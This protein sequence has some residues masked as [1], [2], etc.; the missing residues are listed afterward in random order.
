MRRRGLIVIVALGILGASAALAGTAPAGSRSSRAGGGVIVFN[1]GAP[2]YNICETD[3]NG[4]HRRQLTSEGYYN[5]P[6]ISLNGT[7]MVFLDPKG[8][9]TAADGNAQHSRKL[10]MLTPNGAGAPVI[11]PDG[12]RVVWTQADS[13]G[14]ANY[15]IVETIDWDGQHARTFY[16][17]N[18]QAGFAPHG[19]YIC[20]GNSASQ[21]ANTIGVGPTVTA[22]HCP[23]IIAVAGK[24]LGYGSFDWRPAVSPNG[25]YVAD[26]FFISGPPGIALFDARN[27]RYLRSFEA[28]TGS[29]GDP[30]FTPDG[31]YLLFDDGNNIYRA[32]VRGGKPTLLIR[33]AK[34]PSAGL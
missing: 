16:S 22:G 32:P 34:Q 11:S 17:E 20:T 5:N 12:Q 14:V 28:G 3:L 2:K 4:H 21:G 24:S 19:Q 27:G 8:Q 13:G 18:A 31:K 15:Q 10:K 33:H 1:C 30:A 23:R 7:R 6:T 29:D 26:D 9:V 25:A